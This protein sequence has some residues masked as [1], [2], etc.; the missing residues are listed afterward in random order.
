M[1]PESF[2]CVSANSRKRCVFTNTW[3]LAAT[4]PSRPDWWVAAGILPQRSSGALTELPPGSWSPP[5]TPDSGPGRPGGSA[6]SRKSPAAPELRSELPGKGCECWRT[7]DFLR[8]PTHPHTH[9]VSRISE[10]FGES[11]CYAGCV[12]FRTDPKASVCLQ[13]FCVV[14]DVLPTPPTLVCGRVERIPPQISAV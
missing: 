4:K 13:T 5:R 6:A 14:A 9:L 7:C 10:C 3:L 11:L 2:R 1:V 8:T 12:F